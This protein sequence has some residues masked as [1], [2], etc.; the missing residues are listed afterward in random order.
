VTL[1][2]KTALEVGQEIQTGKTTSVEVT[3]KLLARIKALDP[4]LKAFVTVCAEAALSDARQADAEIS[5][6]KIRSPLHGVPIALKDL[7]DTQGVTTTYGM[8]IHS[9]NVPNKDSTVAARLKA[10]G[11]ILLGKL[12]LTEG[13][14]AR[15]HPAVEP[16]VNPW[17]Q[18]YWV[19]VSSSGSGVAT[20]AGLCF[21]SIGSDTGGSIRFPSAANGIVGI[22]PTW[23]RVSRAGALPLAYTLDHIGPMTRSVKDAAAMLEIIAGKDTDD[24]TTSPL[25]V[26]NYLDS[27]EADVKS[28]IVGVDWRYISDG[29]DN[30]LVEAIKNAVSILTDNGATIV[31]VSI[32]YE[33]VANG[34]AVTCAVETAHAHRETYP[35]RKEEYGAIGDLIA[36]GLSLPAS[37]YLEQELERRSFKSEL[38]SIFS[39]VD[40]LI[41]PSMSYAT[42]DR[43]G[44]PEV[45]QA[46]RGR[47]KMLRFTAPFD[48]SGNP[49][50][51]LPWYKGNE[52]M[53][54]SIQLVA[55]DFEEQTLINAGY[56]LE[57]AGGHGNNHPDI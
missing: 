27:I 55:R 39:E 18:R 9:G 56:L 8:K 42:V 15:H 10:A 41:C 38:D 1:H 54:L 4:T 43:E 33:A 29:I 5:E 26:P 48:Y 34:W 24:D 12:K 57:Q 50:L 11:A 32:P 14:Y 44:S 37:A 28:L 16:P 30:E 7:L 52:G 22:K 13:A 17:D 25:P 3:S 40:L 46:E 53:P 45:G 6:G 31:D 19:G 49:T 21:A 36:L 35:T 47:V 20:A 2:F 23:G 51:S